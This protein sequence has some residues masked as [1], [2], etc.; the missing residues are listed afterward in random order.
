MVLETQR[1]LEFGRIRS[2]TIATVSSWLL[3]HPMLYCAQEV[4]KGS[5]MASI[6]FGEKQRQPRQRA[7]LTQWQIAERIGVSDAYISAL[8]SG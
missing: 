3:R 7:G 5:R 6:R 1:Y 4:G 8:E 2:T